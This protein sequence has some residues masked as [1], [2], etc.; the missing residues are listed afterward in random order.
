MDRL[1]FAVREHDLLAD[2]LVLVE[3]VFAVVLQ[4]PVLDSREECGEAEVFVLRPDIERVVVAA[5]ATDTHTEENLSDALST[6]ERVA[7]GTEEVRRRVFVCASAS[8]KDF[9]RE[10]VQRPIRLEPVFYPAI[11][12][13]HALAI[14]RFLLVAQ[15][16]RPLHRP[17]FGKLLLAQKM[18]DKGFALVRVAIGEKRPHTFRRRGDATRIEVRA[19]NERGIRRQFGWLQPQ[20][21]QLLRNEC[22]EALAGAEDGKIRRTRIGNEREPHGNL[23]RKVAYQHDGF[24]VL[25]FHDFAA[26]LHIHNAD[27]CRFVRGERSHIALRAIGEMGHNRQC[28]AVGR[29]DQH[30]MLWR[31]FELR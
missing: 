20:F 15:Q 22:I 31:D 3:I 23:L 16:V 29:R 5:G 11:V 28:H 26:R 10:F 30:A 9:F 2:E 25:E 19:A 13:L 8:R 18:I 24:A 6:L 1:A 4:N 12:N 21:L 17:E 7:D 27:I 14:E